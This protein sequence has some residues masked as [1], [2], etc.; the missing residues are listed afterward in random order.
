MRDSA[1]PPTTRDLLAFL[2][3]HRGED[4]I[5]AGRGA[6][7]DGSR[8]SRDEVSVSRKAVYNGLFVDSTRVDVD[9]LEALGLLTVLPD[10]RHDALT[11]R[12]DEARATA[13]LHAFSGATRNAEDTL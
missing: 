1:L 7:I 12:I 5:A 13:A 9:E 8:R 2:M 3:E 10:E 11:V 4:C 6:S